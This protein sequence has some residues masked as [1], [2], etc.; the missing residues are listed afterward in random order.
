MQ[1]KEAIRQEL[2]ALRENTLRVR[3]EEKEEREDLMAMWLHREEDI[4]ALKEEIQ[5]WRQKWEER[6]ENSKKMKEGRAQTK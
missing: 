4:E 6:R 2:I 1:E 3:R 5:E